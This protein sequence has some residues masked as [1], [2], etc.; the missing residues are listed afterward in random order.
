[1]PEGLLAELDYKSFGMCYVVSWMLELI[2]Y[3]ATQKSAG[4]YHEATQKFAGMSCVV[5]WWTWIHM[6]IKWSTT[7]RE[8]GGRTVINHRLRHSKSDK[9]A[10]WQRASSCLE[11]VGLSASNIW[12]KHLPPVL[13]WKKTSLYD[14]C[15]MEKLVCFDTSLGWGQ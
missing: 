10:W 8:E 6:E 7:K 2:Y 9:Q 5:L 4:I 15:Q 11:L 3:G 13:E 12:C 1:M 14:V